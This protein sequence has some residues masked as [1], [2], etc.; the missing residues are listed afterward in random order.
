[1]SQKKKKN[2]AAFFFLYPTPISMPPENQMVRPTY[3]FIKPCQ[4]SQ[5]QQLM[6]YSCLLIDPQHCS[7]TKSSFE[8][9]P[10]QIYLGI[11]LT[12][13]FDLIK[14]NLSTKSNSLPGLFL[15]EI[16]DLKFL[17]KIVRI[18]NNSCF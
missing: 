16:Y 10:L 11:F 9:F 1:M 18:L 12:T 5:I 15:H 6:A 14:H 17:H 4:K 8:G 13:K 3:L 7:M 2:F